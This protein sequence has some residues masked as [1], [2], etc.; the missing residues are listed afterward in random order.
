MDILVNGGS[1]RQQCCWI[2][3]KSD[4]FL[5]E[6]C[7]DSRLQYCWMRSKPGGSLSEYKVVRA[8]HSTV[9]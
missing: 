1:N 4:G 6:F 5:I 3:D 2:K 7:G 9:G 8:D